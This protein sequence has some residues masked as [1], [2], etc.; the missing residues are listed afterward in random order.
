MPSATKTFG[1]P[2]VS[3]PIRVSGR[4]SEV[5]A[6]KATMAASAVVATPMEASPVVKA[7]Q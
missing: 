4:T 7:C 2:S 3:L 1:A 5:S 6:R